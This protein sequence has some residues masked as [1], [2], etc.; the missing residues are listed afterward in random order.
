MTYNDQLHKTNW[1]EYIYTHKWVYQTLGKAD[2]CE[3]DLSHKSKKYE[4]ANV[5]KK[6]RREASDWKQLCQS[7]HRKSDVTLKTRL[8]KSIQ[9]IGNKWRNTP[10]VQI[11]KSGKKI[12]YYN[13]INTASQ[14]TKILRT[15][16]TNC[17]QNR[18]KTAGGYMWRYI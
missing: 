1:N 8:L 13:S 7:C 18:S 2:H 6:Y 4:W 15:S 14:R 3:N 9:A 16:I 5:S 10:I 17:L 11:A 12:A